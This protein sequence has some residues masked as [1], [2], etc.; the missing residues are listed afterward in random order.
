MPDFYI[1]PIDFLKIS[2]IKH[3]IFKILLSLDYCSI[4]DIEYFKNIVLGTCTLLFELGY[5]TRNYYA[6]I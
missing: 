4:L 6:Y 3:L 2:V 5:S 1:L